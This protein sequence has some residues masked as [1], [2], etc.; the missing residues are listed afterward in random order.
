MN[1]EQKKEKIEIKKARDTTRREFLLTLF[2]QTPNEHYQEKE[3]NGYWLIK[4]WNGDTQRW[5]VAIYGQES[6]K[7]FKEYKDNNK[8]IF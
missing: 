1:K 3:I 8:I 5:Q 2:N 7:N 6:F 4:Q